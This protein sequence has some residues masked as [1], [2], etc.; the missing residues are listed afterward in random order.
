MQPPNRG[1]RCPSESEGRWGIRAS[2]FALAM[3]GASGC[4]TMGRHPAAFP[5]MPPHGA[6]TLA[7]GAPPVAAPPGP[8][9]AP[10]ASV[11]TAARKVVPHA[12]VGFAFLAT[13]W[14]NT[15]A[16]REVDADIDMAGWACG[17]LCVGGHKDKGGFL[18]GANAY[19]GPRT[20]VQLVGGRLWSTT[21]AGFRAG[22]TADE[23]G[24]VAL[25]GNVDML[26][27]TGFLDRRN[28]RLAAG[29]AL[30][31]SAWSWKTRIP[32][33]DALG[34]NDA[35]TVHLAPGLLGSVNLVLPMM[36]G[37]MLG[38]TAMA[39]VTHSFSPPGVLEFQPQPVTLS[40]LVLAAGLEFR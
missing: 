40:S 28:V 8:R 10:D 22:T 26:A 13:A 1:S 35:H 14:A 34:F 3:W 27:L 19:V 23:S 30:L 21:S 7:D 39:E 33:A 25:R 32:T 6:K 15:T 16:G 17:A 4:A 11:A 31:R 38:L 24:S 29:P 37:V 2:I 18:A 36:G 20:G 9:F 5:A 12:A